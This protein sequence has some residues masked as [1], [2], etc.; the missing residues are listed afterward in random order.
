MVVSYASSPVA[1]V[2]YA[3]PRPETRAHRRPGGRLLPPGRVRGRARGHRRPP[4]RPARSSTS[5]SRPAVQADIPLNMFVSPALATA[6]I[7][8]DY[9]AF[10]A[11][12]D[13]PLSLD[14]A[15][16]QAN[17]EALDRGMDPA[18]PALSR[19]AALLLAAPPGRLPRAVLRLARRLDRRRAGCCPRAASTR[20]RCSRSGRGRPPSRCSRSRWRSRWAAPALT[21]LV[22]LPAAWVFARFTFPGKS[23]ARALVTVP[24]VLPT[25]VVASAFL[26]LL[27]P[28]SPVNALLEARAGPGRA[29]AA[30][31][32]VDR[33][34]RAGV[35]LLQHRGRDPARG[36]PLGAPRPAGGGGG[37]DAGRLARGARSGR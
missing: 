18:R 20:A 2:I 8:A 23:V 7:P 21:L 11:T 1:E 34:H 36:R 17:R 29:A 15:A 30:P 26:A 25:V 32:R 6:D 24:F 28:R 35:G 33:G 5:C 3:D 12:P 14:P 16:I 31:R 4:R 22:G 10:T 37:P 13:A 27:G 19:R 9:A